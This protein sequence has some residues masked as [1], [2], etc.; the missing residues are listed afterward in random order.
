MGLFRRKKEHRA[1]P[2]TDTPAAKVCPVLQVA[3][4]QGSGD[5]AEQ[6]DAF[7]LSLL[8]EYE[9]KGLLAVLCDGMGGME[10]G[11]EIALAC[12][13][14][15]LSAFTLPADADALEAFDAE[16]LRLN[17][18]LYRAHGGRGG[19]TLVLAYIRGDKLHF[20]CLGDS[21]LFL[22]RNEEIL[23]LNEHQTYGNDLLRASI[24]TG[25]DAHRALSDPQADALMSFLGC[26]KPRIEGSRAPLTLIPGDTLVLCSDGVSG[27][28]SRRDLLEAFSG[29]IQAGA[30]TIEQMIKETAKPNQD[31]YTAI[32]CRYN[33][34]PNT[35]DKGG[36]HETE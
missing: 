28:V 24:P 27:T 8:S 21:D 13:Q 22:L 23:A 11:R 36:H 29:D 7:G 34:N 19:S 14:D 4:L 1:E 15:I 32:I 2:A 6:Q 5:R 17:G 31:N 35:E 33:G 25:A 16:L 12:V 26:E 3:N 9:E 20:R 30:E 18:E 10:A